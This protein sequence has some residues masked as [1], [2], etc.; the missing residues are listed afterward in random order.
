[1]T[2]QAPK[3]DSIRRRCPHRGAYSLV[4][5]LAVVTLMGILALVLV[6]RFSGHTGQAKTN[7]CQVNKANIEVQVQ[8]WYRQNGTWPASDLSDIGGD[9]KYFPDGLPPCPVDGSRYELDTTR[10]QVRGHT[11]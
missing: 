7:S 11:H 8:L 10:Y 6:P 1:M 2:Q 9:P 4:E 5:I 3:Y